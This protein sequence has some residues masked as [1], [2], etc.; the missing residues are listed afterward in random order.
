MKQSQTIRRRDAAA[1][2][3]AILNSA[4]RLFATDSYENVGIREIASQAGADAALVSRYFGSKEE[5]FTEVLS[6]G[7]R[8]LDFIGGELTGL[9]ERVADLLLDP[10]EKNEENPMEEILILLHSATSPVAAPLVQASI[11]ERFNGPFADIIGGENAM[12]RSQLFGALLMGISITRRISGNN[13]MSPGERACMHRRISEL[14]ATAI[15]PF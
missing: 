5:L 7:K 9:P 3:A 8:G 13:V 2:R 6:S 14:I 12:I 1:T 15:R 11:H 4:R 10:P